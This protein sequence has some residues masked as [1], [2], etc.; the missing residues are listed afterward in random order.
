MS[1]L[2]TY[3]WLKFTRCEHSTCLERL[4]WSGSFWL[5][6]HTQSSG[7]FAFFDWGWDSFSNDMIVFLIF[8]GCIK[9]KT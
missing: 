4:A 3:I 8:V 2:F 9:T 1:S 6:V 5:L 7:T